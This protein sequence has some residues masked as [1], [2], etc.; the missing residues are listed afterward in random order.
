MEEQDQ[1]PPADLNTGTRP[2]NERGNLI[3]R[4]SSRGR[5][6]G[7]ANQMPD[8]VQGKVRYPTMLPRVVY[9]LDREPRW[10][11]EVGPQD[12]GSQPRT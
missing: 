3:L 6:N 12:A 11:L 5:G 8:E 9:T 1:E 4:A 10:V 2:A 7:L